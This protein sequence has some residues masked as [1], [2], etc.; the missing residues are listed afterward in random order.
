M[1]QIH[2][3]RRL[4][5]LKAMQGR[6]DAAN[7]GRAPVLSLPCWPALF[8]TC[9]NDSEKLRFT[10]FW[11]IVDK[12]KSMNGHMGESEI[13]SISCPVHTRSLPS[14]TPR[15]MGLRRSSHIQATDRS[16]AQRQCI[17][18]NQ[19]D[20]EPGNAW[21]QILERRWEQICISLQCAAT[22]PLRGPTPR[23][24]PFL[25]SIPPRKRS[26]WDST[27]CRGRCR[28]TKDCSNKSTPRVWTQNP[29]W[30]RP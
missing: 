22:H 8:P 12:G 20:P 19:Q 26:S 3:T 27:F 30:G 29:A 4:R 23:A 2:V 17:L 15:L 10:H 28:L 13:K 7:G 16:M 21:K 6:A 24:K 5:Y 9:S 18:H 1:D 14:T 11:V 25:F